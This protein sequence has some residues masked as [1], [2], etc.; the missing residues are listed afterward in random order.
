MLSEIADASHRSV[1]RAKQVKRRAKK[2]L[3]QIG[4]IEILPFR[5]YGTPSRVSVSG[6]VLESKGVVHR[7]RVEAETGLWTNLLASVRRFR[8]E[9][10]PGIELSVRIGDT[11][12]T[13]V[14]DNEG[15]FDVTVDL[16][17][18][19][20][21]GWHDAELEI[22]K[23]WVGGERT[24]AIAQVLV[25]PEEPEFG[26][27]SDLDDTVVVSRATD[28]MKMIRIVLFQSARTRTPFP[29]VAAFYRA[30]KLGSDGRSTNPIFYVSRSA[31]NLYDLFEAFFAINDI[32]RGPLFLRDLHLLEARSEALGIAQ[33]KLSR[34]HTLMETYPKMRFVL[35]GDS[36]QRDPEVYREVVKAYPGRVRAIYIRDVTRR[37]RD[38]EVAQIVREVEALGVPMFRSD[39][40]DEAA[41]HAARLG[42]ISEYQVNMVEQRAEQ[43]E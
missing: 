22:A 16:P 21:P 26:V 28:R 32:P 24:R 20:E 43:D 6:R 1:T 17:E 34:I 36:G 41:R 31:W 35:I 38:R 19:L 11:E 8:S 42:M 18:P 29:G 10:I 37:R 2:R 3:G 25:P 40:S 23:S 12:V 39:H 14:T 30:L 7:E 27:I 15:Y 4:P 9:E 5:G 13:T 33:D